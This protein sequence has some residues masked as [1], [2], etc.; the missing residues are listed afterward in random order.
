MEEPDASVQKA[1]FHGKL[2][3]YQTES[4]K[5]SKRIKIIKI[6]QTGSVK[7]MFSQTAQLSTGKARF[8]RYVLYVATIA[9]Y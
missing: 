5:I 3:T 4:P 2:N 7:V 8:L 1:F 9:A 6:H